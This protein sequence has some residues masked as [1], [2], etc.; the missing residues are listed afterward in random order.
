MVRR[1]RVALRST[2]TARGRFSAGFHSRAFWTPRF[3]AF[4]TPPLASR[5]ASTSLVLGDQWSRGIAPRILFVHLPQQLLDPVAPV[6]CLVVREAQL[7]DEAQ[8]ERRAHLPAQPASRRIDP[9]RRLL[10]HV[11]LSVDGP[12]DPRLAQVGRHLHARDRHQPHARILQPAREELRQLLLHQLSH[13]LRPAVRRHGRSSSRR[14]SRSASSSSRRAAFS[15]AGSGSRRGL[16]STSPCSVEYVSIS[17]SRATI[18]ATPSAS[19]SRTT[20]SST[21]FTKLRSFATAVT[22]TTARCH[23]SFSPTSA[24]LTLYRARTRSVILRS[25]WRFSLS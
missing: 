22:P 23:T 3:L 15:S 1:T 18:S 17:I 5:C 16:S 8:P 10:A 9:A 24:M 13:P 2:S 11:H 19:T 25:A 4:T 14:Y 20:L 12:V 6:D 21:S 7:R